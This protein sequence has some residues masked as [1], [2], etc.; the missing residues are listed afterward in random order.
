MQGRSWDA[1][2]YYRQT[3]TGAPDMPEAICGLGISLGSICDWRGRGGVAEAAAVAEDGSLILAT[4]GAPE[5]DG[6]LTRMIKSCTDQLSISYTENVGIVRTAHTLDRWLDIVMSVKGRRLTDEEYQRWK[7]CFS[8]FFSDFS[9]PEKYI[10]EAGFFIRFIEWA[11]RRLKRRWYIEMYGHHLEVMKP[12]APK[13]LK[14]VPDA[15]RRIHIP[16]TMTVPQ[17]PSIL[18][19]HTVSFSQVASVIIDVLNSLHS[20]YPHV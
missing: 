12:V 8:Q 13:E 14:S 4:V 1:I 5:T 6:W 10:N 3:L 20:Q 15:Y 16:D 19:F 9:R 18:P 11:E 17:T 7:K 2:S